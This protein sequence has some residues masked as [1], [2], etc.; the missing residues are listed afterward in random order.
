[1]A[2]SR[3]FGNVNILGRDLPQGAWTYKCLRHGLLSAASVTASVEL[4][5]VGDDNEKKAVVEALNQSNLAIS[6][7]LKEK[8]PP[9]ITVLI[10][11]CF[12]FMEAWIGSWDRAVMHLASSA[13]M[14]EQRFA[15]GQISEQVAWYVELVNTSVPQAL[16]SPEIL[17]LAQNANDGEDDNFCS[18]LLW[19]IREA[20]TGIQLLDQVT[21][22]ALRL[23]PNSCGEFH[24]ILASHQAQMRFLSERWKR[25]AKVHFKNIDT[26]IQ[27]PPPPVT[28]V[29]TKAIEMMDYFLAHDARYDSLVLG[30][31]LKMIQR[32]LPLFIAGTNF[33]IRRDAALSIPIKVDSVDPE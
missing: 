28:P 32:S 11:F 14:C 4:F 30:M 3:T 20:I 16:R 23:K 33:Q 17:K 8:P 9:E 12:W 10:A 2:I 19:G 27:L 22:E 24:I 5:A 26:N 18:R 13:K 21:E 7:M 1:M 31:R 15:A 25:Y 6:S 29:Y